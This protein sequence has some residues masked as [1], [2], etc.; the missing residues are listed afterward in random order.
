MS[1]RA[2]S[3]ADVGAGTGGNPHSD[4]DSRAASSPPFHSL[5]HV[6]CDQERPGQHRAHPAAAGTR[7]S[8]PSGH[9]VGRHPQ[10]SPSRRSK[11]LSLPSGRAML[12]STWS[13]GRGVSISPARQKRKTMQWPRSRFR[14]WISG[15]R[16]V[17][18]CR[19]L[20]V[21]PSEP[22]K[23]RADVGT[24]SPVLVCCGSRLRAAGRGML[25]CPIRTLEQAGETDRS[26]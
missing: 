18:R 8:M 22:R 9:D 2:R 15:V 21:V 4:S 12:T 13:P 11:P 10:L 3:T 7:I 23:R 26:E 6:T 16:S 19:S 24:G 14:S 17:W 25:S 5:R 1:S 20:V